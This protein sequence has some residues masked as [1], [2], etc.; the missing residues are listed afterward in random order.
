MFTWVLPVSAAH[1][2]L[3]ISNSGVNATI[4]ITKDNPPVINGTELSPGDEIGVFTSRGICS[5]LGI[6]A[7]GNLSI[8]VWGDDP[9]ETGVRGFLTGESYTIKLWVASDD[10]E[11]VAKTTYANGE[12]IYEPN[13]ISIIVLLIVSTHFRLDVSSTGISATITIPS[14]NSPSI[15]D[16]AISVNDEI[17]IYTPRGRCAGFGVWN[18]LD[19]VITVWGDN[20][21]VSGLQGFANGELYSYRLWD[22]STEN[23]YPAAATYQLGDGSFVPQGVTVI[24]TLTYPVLDTLEIPLLAGW[25]HVSSNIMPY[26]YTM[27]AVF[28]DILDNVLIIKNGNGEVNWPQFKVEQ[29]EEWVITDGY[30]VKMSVAD[31]LIIHGLTAL[32]ENVVYELNGWNFISFLGPDGRSPDQAFGSII[33]SIVLAKD[34]WGQVFWPQYGID[35]IGALRIGQ[36]YLVKVSEPVTFSYVE[37]VSK[38]SA[39]S[40]VRYPHYLCVSNTDNNA[41]ILVA[42]TISPS[43]SGVS[44]T[45]GDEIGVFTEDGLC[46]GCGT[47]ENENLVITVW[48]NDAQ[49]TEK[50]GIKS[51]ETYRFR[52]WDN[53]FGAEYN[54]S[55]TYASGN[56]EYL[57]N[58]LVILGSL[59]GETPVYVDEKASPRQFVLSQNYPNPFNP[60]TSI[61]FYLPESEFVSLTVYNTLGAVVDTIVRSSFSAGEHTVNFDAGGLASGQ[62]IYSIKTGRYSDSKKFTIVK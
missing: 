34:G 59:A 61:S 35:Q 22:V 9:E 23:E 38:V 51:G 31:T 13:G 10:K 4:L 58:D 1:F 32:P 18:G 19:L 12:G 52:I 16:V 36:G 49:T 47:W 55:A 45:Y 53:E 33:D 7:G 28:E 27:E 42:E 48:G 30:Q 50:D 21:N 29:I 6:W 15:N 3:D 14:R 44:L 46:V 40:D 39:V 41:S 60:L 24:K 54:A 11:Y 26:R 5:G 8:T 20:P 57:V 56:D 37:T 43:I 62:Y 17:G 2:S 25:N